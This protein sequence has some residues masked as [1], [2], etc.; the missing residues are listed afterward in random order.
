MAITNTYLITD[1]VTAERT[2]STPSSPS[3]R[4]PHDATN[5]AAMTKA[6]SAHG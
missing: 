2:D 1:V 3:S 6:S 5:G 4:G